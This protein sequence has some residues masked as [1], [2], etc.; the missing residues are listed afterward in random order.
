MGRLTDSLYQQWRLSHGG[1]GVLL[2][3]GRPALP[4]ARPQKAKRQRIADAGAS[5]HNP[6]KGATNHGIP[7]V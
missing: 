2:T 4:F 3:T 5:V 1:S 6:S 7:K